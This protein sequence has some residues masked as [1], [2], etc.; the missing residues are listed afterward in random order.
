MRHHTYHTE[1]VLVVYVVVLG[2]APSLLQT[3]DGLTVLVDTFYNTKTPAIF[4]GQA[5]IYFP[6]LSYISSLGNVKLA[7]MID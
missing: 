6:I 1:P 5:C 3:R 4:A 2:H 7:H